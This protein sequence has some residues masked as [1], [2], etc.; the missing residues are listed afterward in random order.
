MQRQIS[1]EL[2]MMDENEYETMPKIDQ[3]ENQDIAKNRKK[4]S[5]YN[6]NVKKKK[7]KKLPSV[8]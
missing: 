1:Q 2:K 3:S 5:S 8:Q 6:K 4:K 7:S